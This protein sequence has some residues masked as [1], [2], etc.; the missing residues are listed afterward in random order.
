MK[1]TLNTMRDI[2]LISFQRINNKIYIWFWTW[3]AWK[4]NQKYGKYDINYIKYF[5][6]SNDK[7]KKKMSKEQVKMFFSYDTHSIFR[8]SKNKLYKITDMKRICNT[9][10][11]KIKCLPC[12]NTPA[13]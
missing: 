10:G 3:N 9:T 11:L 13:S 7:F 4:F 5:D 12:T 6:R 8:T 1:N 2:Y